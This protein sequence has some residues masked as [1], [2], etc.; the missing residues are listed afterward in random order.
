MDDLNDLLNTKSEN[1]VSVEI[2]SLVEV[3]STTIKPRGAWFAPRL[4]VSR[5][6]HTGIHRLHDHES[7]KGQLPASVRCQPYLIFRNSVSVYELISN[8]RFHQELV[9]DRDDVE[10]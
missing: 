2:E 6:S 10:L 5:G 9:N 4:G 8:P 7:Q 3:I 1:D